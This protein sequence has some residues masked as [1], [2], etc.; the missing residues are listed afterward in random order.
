MCTLA[1][2]HLKIYKTKGPFVYF[3]SLI[4]PSQRLIQIGIYCA[5]H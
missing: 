4:L 1:W 3:H 2:N 5:P